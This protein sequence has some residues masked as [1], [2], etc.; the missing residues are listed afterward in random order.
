MKI[1]GNCSYSPFSGECETKKVDRD[2]AYFDIDRF[3]DAKIQLSRFS[4]VPVVGSHYLIEAQL[5]DSG[6]CTPLI[7][8]TVTF[9]KS[10][11]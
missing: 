6:S 10:Q 2:F 11:H 9:V 7:I 5:I 4:I 1:G 8:D 3:I